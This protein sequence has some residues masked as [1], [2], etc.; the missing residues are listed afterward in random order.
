MSLGKKIAMVTLG[1]NSAAD[2][3]FWA[4][5]HAHESFLMHLCKTWVEGNE[6][7]ARELLSGAML[8]A[9]EGAQQTLEIG[10]YKAWLAKVVRNYCIDQQRKKNSD[11]QIKTDPELLAPIAELQKTGQSAS[12][13]AVAVKEESYRGLRARV[14]GLPT[15][16][17]EV[18]VLRAYQEM[19]YDEIALRLQISTDNVRK[20]VQLAR[21]ML[22]GTDAQQENVDAVEEHKAA[23][24]IL[25]QER[26]EFQSPRF[27]EPVKLRF[28]DGHCIEMPVFHRFQPKRLQQKA[29]TLLRY[30][31]RHPGGWKKELEYAKICWALGQADMAL[32]FM[33]SVFERQ[34]AL[35]VVAYTY[36]E[37][38]R[39]A[40]APLKEAAIARKALHANGKKLGPW[41]RLL[42][43]FEAEAEGR[44]QD[45]VQHCLEAAQVLPLANL[46]AAEI[47]LRTESRSQAEDLLRGHILLSPMDR[48]AHL[49]MGIAL[50]GT[51]EARQFSKLAARRFPHDAYAVAAAFAAELPHS[52]KG[53]PEYAELKATLKRIQKLAQGSLLALCAKVA[54][55]RRWGKPDKG[56]DLLEEFL[57]A[58]PKHLQALQAASF[59]AAQEGRTA[60]QA[61]YQAR[62]DAI[63][64]AALPL[65]LTALSMFFVD[66]AS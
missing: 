26:G 20:R 45:A 42:M 56:T 46:K 4:H 52:A 5:W 59:F 1:R 63:D 28:A 3:L 47:L 32:T 50:E 49:L 55:H 6:N 66:A 16:L 44:P 54:W 41:Q 65:H 8:H 58:W 37:M 19:S 57:T 9:W 43:G 13:E 48:E 2:E 12:V 34:P 22:L 35:P 17:R 64:P 29:E 39:S 53:S 33:A 40:K 23:D 38:L 14:D 60:D 62:V 11:P 24:G 31:E 7:E 27:A 21:Q 18:M 15:H 25:A 36:L 61:A 30:L 10:N 51:A